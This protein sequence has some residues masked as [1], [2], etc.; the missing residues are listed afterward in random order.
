MKALGT[1]GVRGGPVDLIAELIEARYEV[2]L[3]PKSWHTLLGK[4]Y[5]H[6]LGLL[7]LANAAF[8]SAPSYWLTNQN[9][10]HHAIF[11]A[12]QK[13]LNAKGHVA[14]RSFKNKIGELLD[15]GVMLDA[16]SPFS[17]ACLVV[18]DCFR[19]TNNRRNHPPNS[20]PYD[21][22]S[23]APLL[24]LTAKERNHFAQDLKAAL[25]VFVGLMP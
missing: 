24:H 23:A 15:L 20:H 7:K 17:K 8:M 19:D 9:S 2:R 14:A 22:K 1:V 5:L 13:H 12:L 21:K 3:A 16:S 25:V 18:A 10:F 6:A 11:L 4:D